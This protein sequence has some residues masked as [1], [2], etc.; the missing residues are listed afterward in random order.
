[1]RSYA[2]LDALLVEHL[3]AFTHVQYPHLRRVAVVGHSAGGQVTHRWALLSNSP[4]WEDPVIH[5]VSVDANPRS[6]CY[7]DEQ[8]VHSEDGTFRVPDDDDIRSCPGYDQWHWGLNDGGYLKCP[9]RDEALRQLN[10][11]EMARRYAGRNVI[12]LS[13]QLDTLP[14]NDECAEQ[15]CFRDPTDRNERGITYG[16]CKN[17]FV[18]VLYTNG[19]LLRDRHMTIP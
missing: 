19:T 8:R 6:Y 1:V 16:V 9:Y 12:Y 4:T 10:A 13:G 14:S 7:L 17:C 5:I 11:T 15:L 3:V 18:V 2:V